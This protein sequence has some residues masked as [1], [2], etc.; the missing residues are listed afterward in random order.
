MVARERATLTC[1][2]STISNARKKAF[3]P[4]SAAFRI[5][6]GLITINASRYE[7]ERVGLSA[8]KA[9]KWLTIVDLNTSAYIG[10]MP[11]RVRT[12]EAA[13]VRHPDLDV[14]DVGL[15]A[16]KL[17]SPVSVGTASAAIMNMNKG[18]LSGVLL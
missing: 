3:A 5:K 14:H 15:V 6:S 13:P 4:V 10:L 1:V 12:L 17:L 8:V 7:R 2:L 9:R 16:R 11:D 18:P